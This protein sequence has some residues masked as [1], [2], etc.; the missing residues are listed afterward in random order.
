[1]ISLQDSLVSSSAR[2]M[3]IKV[4]PDLT[5]KKQYYLGRTYWV[6]KEPI[7]SRYFRFQEEEY[8]ILKMVNGEMSIEEIKRS[9]EKQFPPQKVTLNELHNFLG[10]LH[11]SGLIVAAVPNQGNELLKRRDKRNRSELL[12]KFSN[13]LAIRFK[14]IDPDR[15][16]TF[17]LPFVRWC[18]NP[19][20]VIFCILFCLSA[21]SLVLIHFDTFRSKLPEFY[22]FF[23]P[24][25]ILLMSVTLG[26]TKILHEFGHGVTAKYFKGECHKMGLMFLVLTPCLYVDVSDSWLLPNKWHRMAIGAGGVFV[27]L[28]LASICTYFWWY[29]EPGLLNNLALNVMFVSSVS[30]IM[31]NMNPLLRFDG[32]YILADYMEI[33]NM[34]IKATKILA[35]KCSQ[36]FLGLEKQEDPFLP[37]SNQIAFALFSVASFCYRWVILAS[38]LMFLF[39][40]FE[41]YGLKIIG[42]CIAM[43]SIVSLFLMPGYKVFK[44]F[45]VPGRLHKVKKVRFYSSL[46]GL[47]AIIAFLV[48]FP[49]PYTVITPVI[50]ELRP[51]HSQQVYVPNIQG[52]CRL[53]E[54]NVVP[55]QFVS[56]GE[57][58]AR[59]E[60]FK[61]RFEIVD[62]RGKINVLEREIEMI[63]RLKSIDSMAALELGPKQKSLDTNRK[64]LSEKERNWNDLLLKAPLDG[65]VVPPQWKPQRKEFDEQ[66]ATWWG[67]PLEK[68]NLYATFEPGTVF[69]SVG[70]P[71]FMEA[72][73][74][75]NQNKRD[76]LNIGQRVELK[77]NEY[78]DRVFEGEITQIEEQALDTVDAQLSTRGGG[79]V[80]TTTRQDGL[81]QPQNASYRVRMPLDNPDLSVKPGMT[82]AAKVH[83]AP[84]TLGMRGWRFFNETFN[85]KL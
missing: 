41:P 18:F 54:I 58:L 77:L 25:N 10:Q 78:P 55:G 80:P 59:M 5:A 69:C 1:M 36:W 46:T 13:I 26:A 34:R 35:E 66:L 14:G 32:Y 12:Q 9:F 47:F 50:M 82:G 29:S 56:K 72:V 2:R 76:F 31:F 81:E 6:V 79:E 20:F 28:V 44:F 71:E 22:T 53:K 33:P 63:N 19:V 51:S 23:S 75:D 85:F 84:Q 45:R 37:K 15:M 39:K 8:A 16:F 27:E 60:N 65:V 11:Q 70:A 24:V 52:G 48:F 73:L 68:E 57:I 21:A 3:P 61:L 38:I 30:T 67:S 42:Q 4:R 83:V 17:A 7:G 62:Y 64:I 40:V 49:L 74:V 43:M